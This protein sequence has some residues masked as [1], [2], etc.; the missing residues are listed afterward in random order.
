MRRFFPSF[1]A[2]KG[3]SRQVGG[4]AGGWGGQ[5]GAPDPRR[6]NEQGRRGNQPFFFFF[7]AM[8]LFLGLGL[9]AEGGGRWE[10][11]MAVGCCLKGHGL[12]A[13]LGVRRVG[14]PAECTFVAR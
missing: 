3:L 6:M 13:A 12:C 9:G 14:G 1:S 5:D 8:I 2:K 11:L 7:L 10:G 4:R